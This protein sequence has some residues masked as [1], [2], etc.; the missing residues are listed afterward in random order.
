MLESYG[1]S[2]T[3]RYEDEHTDGLCSR[4]VFGLNTF[5]ANDV[6]LGWRSDPLQ[7]AFE[8]ISANPLT[9]AHS[10]TLALDD[11]ADETDPPLASLSPDGSVVPIGLHGGTF[12]RDG[13]QPL[14]YLFR[15]AP[16]MFATWSDRNLEYLVRCDSL[17]LYVLGSTQSFDIL[18][19]IAANAPT[20]HSAWLRTVLESYSLVI[21]NEADGWY[22]RAF[23]RTTR[24]LALLSPAMERASDAIESSSWYRENSDRL[25]WEELDAC[26]KISCADR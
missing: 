4:S 15:S 1:Q 21:I 7:I 9:A 6:E 24:D 18:C 17:A 12:Y 23:A 20:N 22:V 3:V 13:D 16:I 10:G 5:R 14:G 2:R 26:L 19:G 8:A 25:E 11:I